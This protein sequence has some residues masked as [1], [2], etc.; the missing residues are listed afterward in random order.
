[1]VGA[2]DVLFALLD[3]KVPLYPMVEL[4][5]LLEQHL[6]KLPHHALVSLV[7]LRCGV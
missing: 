4:F 2:P 1:M 7:F 3:V 6:L 5:G